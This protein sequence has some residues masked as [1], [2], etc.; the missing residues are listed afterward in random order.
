MSQREEERRPREKSSSTWGRVRAQT[1]RTRITR[2]RTRTV[3]P[4]E[5][6]VVYS[7][8][9][10]LSFSA[11]P[12]LLRLLL[13][14]FLLCVL[15]LWCRFLFHRWIFGGIL[16]FF[17]FWCGH[18]LMCYFLLLFL[19]LH[20]H[21]VLFIYDISVSHFWETCVFHVRFFSPQCGACLFCVNFFLLVRHV[22]HHYRKCLLHEWDVFLTCVRHVPHL[23]EAFLST[24]TC[25]SHV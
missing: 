14:F 25:L 6:L 22:S 11:A 10:L 20:F 19:L 21:F 15:F 13:L 16:H 18:L 23:C 3:S 7:S 8:S 4:V 5:A 12:T 9:S 2:P 24:E 1:P 17:S